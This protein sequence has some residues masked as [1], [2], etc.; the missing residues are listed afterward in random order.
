MRFVR[1]CTAVSSMVVPPMARALRFLTPLVLLLA[2]PA[3][4]APPSA[5]GEIPDLAASAQGLAELLSWAALAEPELGPTRIGA[6]FEAA[7]G[8][9]PLSPEA[10]RAVG[11]DPSKPA[12]LTYDAARRQLLV[13]VALADPAR[14]RAH[15]EAMRGRT[16]GAAPVS[17][18][19]G[20]VVGDEPTET[21][22]LL[23]REGDA[24]LVVGAGYKPGRAMVGTS[25][26]ARA[27]KPVDPAKDRRLAAVGALAKRKTR[28]RPPKAML[29]GERA[30]L[31][32]VIEPGD[33]VERVD[34]VLR[35]RSGQATVDAEAVLGMGAEMAL[36]EGMRGKASSAALVSAGRTAVELRAT[37]SKA[38][39][40]EALAR[41]G[42]PPALASLLA[43]PIH[44]GIAADGTVFGAA[45]LA[46]KADPKALVEALKA[47][48]LEAKVRDEV[49]TA[50]LG[51]G[52]LGAPAAGGPA[53]GAIAVDVVPAL[54][55]AAI[56]QHR[57]LLRIKPMEL[58]M[59]RVLMARLVAAT[60]SVTLDASMP[61]NRP[62]AT[63]RLRYDASK[64]GR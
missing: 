57:T 55:L 42:L 27:V 20:F 35:A 30:D 39:L 9:D 38:G 62:K 1:A 5:S 54:L 52:T 32:L 21:V 31:W 33:H 24:V 6:R 43:G 41:A 26:A 25:S 56:E 36:A 8:V 15:A 44:A 23:V 12:R 46:S 61:S 53:R 3:S 18:A 29:D 10:L 2:G 7:V 37:L 19:T 64:V 16:R 34:V 47:K 14:A 11:V 63:L 59:V 58:M 40:R 28:P 51:A 22:A 49:L 60:E 48:G 13:E 45:T 4:A 17:G 50:Q